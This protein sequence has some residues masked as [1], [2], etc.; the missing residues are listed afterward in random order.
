M[1]EEMGSNSMLVNFHPFHHA[2]ERHPRFSAIEQHSSTQI[3]HKHA[4]DGTP[5]GQSVSRMYQEKPIYYES[6]HFLLRLL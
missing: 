2:L 6:S 1:C 3:C 5:A 4:S